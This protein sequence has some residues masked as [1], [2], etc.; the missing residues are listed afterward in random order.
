MYVNRLP[1]LITISHYVKFATL[2][3]LAI[4]KQ[5]ATLAKLLT[6]VMHLYG[7]RGFLVTMV[8]ADREFELSCGNLA[9]AGSSL[10]V[11]AADEHVPKFE[12]FIR[13]AS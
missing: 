2:K 7:S 10:N 6:A 12:C 11:C 1:F 9:A 3:L 8:H 4:N 13:T 5:E